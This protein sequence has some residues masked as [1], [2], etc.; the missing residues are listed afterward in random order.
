MLNDES[1]NTYA[2][3]LKMRKLQ[4][5]YVVV[6]VFL[7]LHCMV[8]R[9]IFTP[10]T[11]FLL[12]SVPITQKLLDSNLE[13]WTLNSAG[14]GQGQRALRGTG[15]LV[16]TR[17]LLNPFTHHACAAFLRHDLSSCSPFLPPS[18][19]TLRLLTGSIPPA[20]QQPHKCNVS[21]VDL[22]FSP[23]G[24]EATF[25]CCH[26]FWCLLLNMKIKKEKKILGHSWLKSWHQECIA[27]PLWIWRSL[28]R[29]LPPRQY[30]KT[31]LLL[32]FF[33]VLF[34]PCSPHQLAFWFV[35]F[36]DKSRISNSFPLYHFDLAFLTFFI[37]DYMA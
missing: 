4:K 35:V 1:G 19:L 32:L 5:C 8:E 31:E 11:P 29:W 3:F 36:S 18:S 6:V 12:K 30:I 2:C 13:A 28:S 23:F 24:A 27:N 17:L 21:V 20:G 14:G 16:Q 10:P 25:L 22:T 7:E 15:T 26:S 37:T 9:F 33:A 34:V